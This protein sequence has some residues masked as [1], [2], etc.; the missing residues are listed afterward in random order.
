MMLFD[1]KS[2]DRV[3]D[4]DGYKPDHVHAGIEISQVEL[5][6]ACVNSSGIYM[7]AGKVVNIHL[8]DLKCGFYLNK[9]IARIRIYGNQVLIDEFSDGAGS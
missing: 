1:D 8:L 6:L 7:A 3:I 9:A 2:F 5:M 4:F